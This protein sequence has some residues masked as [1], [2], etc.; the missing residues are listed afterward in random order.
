LSGVAGAAGGFAGACAGAGGGA[1][2]FELSLPPP[3]HA[4]STNAAARAL[5][6]SFVFIDE[7]PD[8]EKEPTTDATFLVY[9]WSETNTIL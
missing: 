8:G 2:A 4:A 9:R 1:G 3:L 5:R 6:A 7:S